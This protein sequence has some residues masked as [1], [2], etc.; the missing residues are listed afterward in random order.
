MIVSVS[1]SESWDTPFLSLL[2]KMCSNLCSILQEEL[3][4]SNNVG[5]FE[6]LVSLV[7]NTYFDVNC[8]I[9]LHTFSY[10]KCE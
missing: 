3:F 8:I 7:C 9:I 1:D 10:S 2:L 5:I 6:E 4:K